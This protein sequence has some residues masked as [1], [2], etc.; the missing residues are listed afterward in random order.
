[1]RIRRVEPERAEH[2]IGIDLG[3]D[4]DGTAH[5]IAVLGPIDAS[6]RAGLPERADALLTLR[7]SVVAEAP[8][9]AF[10]DGSIDALH[11]LA[12]HANAA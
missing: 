6:V 1:M 10:H 12:R 7:E 2:P 11:E 3:L 9:P 8:V 5:L 4:A